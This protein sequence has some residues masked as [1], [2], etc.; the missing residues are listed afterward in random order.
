MACSVNYFKGCLAMNR[1]FHLKR[2]YYGERCPSFE[3]G[4][5]RLKGLSFERVF[6]G[7]RGLL[8]DCLLLSH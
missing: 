2:V 3:R 6:G 5:W 8:D 4:L 7:E 1:I